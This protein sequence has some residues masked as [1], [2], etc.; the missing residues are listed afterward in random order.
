MNELQTYNQQFGNYLQGTQAAA[1]L[2]NAQ[3][4]NKSTALRDAANIFTQQLNNFLQSAN[5]R[6]KI[7]Q[8]I[9]NN[10]ESSLMNSGNLYNAIFSNAINSY[11]QQANLENAI[12]SNQMSKLGAQIQLQNQIFNNTYGAYEHIAK[13]IL[14]GYGIVSDAATKNTG[15]QDRWI[16]RLLQIQEAGFQKKINE[17]EYAEQIFEERAKLARIGTEVYDRIFAHAGKPTALL[18]AAQEAAQQPALR[19]WNASI[20]L[21]QS[22]TGSL[23]ALSNQGTRTTT[24][25]TH[26]SGGFLGGLFGGITS[27]FAGGLA[28]GYGG[29]LGNSLFGK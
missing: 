12:F 14:D 26:Q 5:F 29:A 3:Y 15:L 7:Q 17:I 16:E 27:A 25:E 18:A 19:L 10:A 28:S 20:G 2:E 24:T 9:F 11:Q 23:V 8:D 6:E 1:N 4:S 13:A 22:A 21:N